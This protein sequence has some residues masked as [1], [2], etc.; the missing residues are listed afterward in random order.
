MFLS[1]L[2]TVYQDML[3]NHRA[4][5][6]GLFNHP[7]GRPVKP[8]KPLELAAM[9]EKITSLERKMIEAQRES[10]LIMGTAEEPDYQPPALA[11]KDD[12][13]MDEEIVIPQDTAG[14]L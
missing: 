2:L 6:D 14:I 5:L 11:L 13:E 10:A 9:A 12:A 4:D 8:V 3:L 1:D 7:D